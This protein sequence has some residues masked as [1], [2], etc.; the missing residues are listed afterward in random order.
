ML[1]LRALTSIGL[2][3]EQWGVMPLLTLLSTA[4]T[5]VKTYWLVPNPFKHFPS[6]DDFDQFTDQQTTTPTM[7][8]ELLVLISNELLKSSVLPLSYVAILTSGKFH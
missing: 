1:S 8:K 2:R 3:V 5:T 4:A 6:L 7:F